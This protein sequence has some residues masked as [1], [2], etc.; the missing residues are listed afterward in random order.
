[1]VTQ[2]QQSSKSKLKHSIPCISS[3]NDFLW[4]FLLCLPNKYYTNNKT[5]AYVGEEVKRQIQQ[6]NFDSMSVS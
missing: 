4:T 1:M 5:W 6:T 2:L 3:E